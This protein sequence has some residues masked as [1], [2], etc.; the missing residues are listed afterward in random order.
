MYAF[1]PGLIYVQDLAN[2]EP[3]TSEINTM[4]QHN[5]LTSGYM[6]ARERVCERECMSMLWCIRQ[7]IHESRTPYIQYANDV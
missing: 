1:C 4:M 2:G 7:E 3:M 5:R 6:C